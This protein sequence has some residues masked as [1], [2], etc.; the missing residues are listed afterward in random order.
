MRVCF[1]GTYEEEYPRNQILLKA[2]K[3]AGVHVY[4]CHANLWKN[5]IHKTETLKSIWKITRLF[6]QLLILYPV[7]LVRYWTTPDHDLVLVGYPGQIDI[8][9][10]KWLVKLRKR[11]IVFD[12]FISLYDAAVED[13][14]LVKRNSI[15]AFLL[16]Q[17]DKTACR[18]ANHLILDT[19]AQIQYFEET[20]KIPKNRFTRI[21]AGADDRLFVPL[22]KTNEREVARCRVLFIGKFTPLHGIETILETAKRLK[23]EKDIYFD[24]IGIGQLYDKISKMVQAEN[25]ENVKLHGWVDYEALPGWIQRSDL[26]LGIFADT[27]KASRVIP[28]KIFQALACAKPVITAKTDAIQELLKHGDS[29]YLIPPG[30]PEALKEAILALKKDNDAALKIAEKGNSAFHLESDIEKIGHQLKNLF[31]HILAT[32]P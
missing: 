24:I 23:N 5:R 10:I 2:M 30:Q 6:Y 32:S 21:F 16:Y 12:I 31:E 9:A 3:Q 18:S 7:L 22:K 14:G 20:F 15:T 29:A 4:E 25:L 13:R 17:L 28:N 8:L 11:P 1:F 27:P 26:C 19:H